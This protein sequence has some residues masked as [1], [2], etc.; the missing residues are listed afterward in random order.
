MKLKAK[1]LSLFKKLLMVM[2]VLVVLSE[3]AVLSLKVI[4]PPMWMWRIA[5]SINPPESYPPTV[6]YQWQNIEQI[7]PS[8]QLAIIASEDQRFPHHHGI[9]WTELRNAIIARQSGGQLRGAS[10]ITQQTAKNLYLWP[11]NS[12]V[13]KLVEA[14][15]ALLLELN[16]DKSRILEIYLNIIEFGPGIYGVEAASQHYYKRSASNL[17]QAQS[18]ALASILPSPYR[19]SVLRPSTHLTNR[20]VWIQRQMRQLGSQHWEAN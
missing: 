16:L 11:S 2:L 19:Y 4:D 6:L 14:Y 15:F 18:A 3:L 12:F 1:M 17:S 5:R 8:I 13:R 20:R 10:T 9:D 7:A